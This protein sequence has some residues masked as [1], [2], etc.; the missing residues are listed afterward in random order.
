LNDKPSTSKKPQSRPG[1][2]GGFD[3][4]LEPLPSPYEEPVQPPNLFHH[5][6]PTPNIAIPASLRPGVAS[7]PNISS[8]EIIPPTPSTPVTDWGYEQELSRTM[9]H[10][11]FISAPDWQSH[12]GPSAFGSMRPHSMPRLPPPDFGLSASPPTLSISTSSLPKRIRSASSPSLLSASSSAGLVQCSGI[13]KKGQR[14]SR[15]IKAGP[16]LSQLDPGVDVERFCQDH[17]TKVLASSG[18]YTRKGG[19]DMWVKFEGAY[20]NLNPQS[21]SSIIDIEKKQRLD[22]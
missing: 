15:K 10:A 7:K 1:F 18:F 12:L 13:T 8:P 21:Q 6:D 17:R 3:P 2:I 14:C 9:Q 22:P 20:K 11:L 16:A 4:E 19:K 5:S